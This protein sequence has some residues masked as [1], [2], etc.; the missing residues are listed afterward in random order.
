M[1]RV[2]VYFNFFH[3]TV[4][5]SHKLEMANNI[6]VVTRYMGSGINDKKLAWDQGSEGWDQG[7]K[8]GIRDQKKLRI[9]FS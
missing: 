6:R 7:S 4:K 3:E 2:H 1:K 8:T 9:N 5:Y